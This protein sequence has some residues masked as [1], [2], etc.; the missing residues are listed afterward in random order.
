MNKLICEECG[1]LFY[2]AA[3]RTL[4]DDG[5]RCE[6]CGGLLQWVDERRAETGEVEV[7]PNG[8]GGSDADEH[9]TE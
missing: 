4:A 8:L 2:S 3:A 9:L 7:G 1:A 6:V 5:V